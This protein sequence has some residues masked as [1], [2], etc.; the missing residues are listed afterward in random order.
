MKLSFYNIPI[1]TGKLFLAVLHQT[2]ASELGIKAGD[3]IKLQNPNQNYKEVTAICEI[4]EEEKY[5]NQIGLYTE[6]QLELQAEKK[7]TIKIK[8]SETPVSVQYIKNK[9]NKH[10]L[11]ETEINE[12]VKDIV[13][14]NLSPAEMSYFIAACYVNGLDDYET[15]FLTKAIVNNGQT[16]KFADGKIV[17]KHCIGGVPGNRTTMLVVPIITAAG[18]KMP[19]TSSRSI[20]SPAGTADTMEVLTNVTVDAKD[21][22]KIAKKVNGFIAWGGGVDIASA[23]DKLIKL[24]HTLSL[25]PQG[26][27]IASIMAKKYAVGSTDVLIDIPYGDEAKVKSYFEG[28]KLKKRF[29]KIGKLLG[30]NTV[31]ILTKGEEPIGNGIG[32]VLEADDV[33][34]VLQQDPKRPKDLEE[35]SLEM[36]GIILEMSGTCKSGKGYKLAKQ[37]LSSKEALNQMQ[38]IIEEQGESPIKKQEVEFKVD[39]KSPQKGKIIKINNKLISLI[40]RTA[41]SPADPYAG[42][43]IYKKL[44]SKVKKGETIL[45]IQSNSNTRLKEAEKIA[46]EEFSK[47][48]KLRQ[49]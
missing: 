27:L 33:M 30:M 16:I 10:S 15:A 32:P 42:L 12:I 25:D 35:K 37:I 3:R 29:E 7:D 1:K 48:I 45:T 23:D 24:R 9:L 39:L 38:K 11:S 41:G 49:I 28:L 14:D 43:Y 2:Q 36:A 18:L 40:A 44:G 31:V 19:K 4:S 5:K 13:E 20:T 17:D 47:L 6:T 26:M 22:E 34:K 8:V 46:K 21:L